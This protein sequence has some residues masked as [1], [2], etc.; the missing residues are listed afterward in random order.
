[1]ACAWLTGIAL[2]AGAAG[3]SA[4]APQE[5]REPQALQAL[6]D[7][8]GQK[9]SW[10]PLGLNTAPWDTAFTGDS[11]QALLP[12]LRS[13]GIGM[14]RYGGG[15]FADDYG[16]EGG[17]QVQDCPHGGS[18]AV[19]PALG[20][21]GC[22]SGT[23]LGFDPFSQ[24]AARLGASTFVT[25]N[26]GTG[27]PTEAAAWV[28]ASR[29]VPGPGVALWEIGNESYACWEANDWL[30]QPPTDYPGFVPMHGQNGK[31][32]PTCPQTT[33][34]DALGTQIMANSYAANA[35]PFMTAMKAADKWAQIGVP[36]AFGS[37]VPGADVPYNDEWNDT[38]LSENADDIG[39]VDAHYYPFTFS[40]STGGG[41][42]TD[43]QVLHALTQIPTL[44][45]QIRTT[46]STYDSRASV[47]VGETNV[48]EAETTTVCQ[49]VGALFAAGD[50]LSWLAAGAQSIDWWNMNNYGNTGS[51]CTKPD[52][53]MFTSPGANQRPRPATPYYGYRLA[54]ILVQ[55][56]AMLSTLPT[57]DLDNV[58]GFQSAL[59]DGKTAVAFLN[60]LTGRPEHVTFPAPAALTGAV[61][62]GRPLRSWSY[63]TVRPRIVAGDADPK[64]L[65]NGITLP[66]ASLTILESG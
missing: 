30:V 14:L 3:P 4:A 7:D 36:W 11:G 63:S 13:A 48:S 58:L 65:A 49:P 55:P 25:V 62:D 47:V 56:D 35:R 32:N 44:Y 57:S 28:T 9:V 51:S 26:Y 10:A 19:V 16:W 33:R 60:T 23:A 38:V 34:G 31:P 1:M 50:V 15:S 29:Q 41:N 21:G 61:A 52:F 12:R 17:V 53:G 27:T 43:Q 22:A 64:S 24:E 5:P 39:F 8:P 40:G 54:S 20:A 46:L 45:G 37:E 42:P 6:R 66:A 2:A 18:D 59:P